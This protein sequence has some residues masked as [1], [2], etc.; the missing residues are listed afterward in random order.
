MREY[1]TND[2]RNIALIGHTGTGKTTLLENALFQAGA[3]P[4]LG[5]V[6]Q[7]N[8]VSDFDDEETRRKVSVQTTLAY[9]EFEGKKINFIDTPGSSDFVGDVRAALRVADGTVILLDAAAGIEIGTEALW[10][11]ADEYHVP[12]LVYVNKMDRE[13]A[14]FY[15][16]LDSIK[17]KFH[18]P[19]VAIQVPI[20]QAGDFRGLIDL[21]NMKAVY[22]DGSGKCVRIEEIPEDMREIANEYREKLRDAAAET[23]DEL[24][25]K[26][27]EGRKL[28]H[29]EIVRGVSRGILDYKIVPVSCGSLEAHVGIQLLMRLIEE[30][31]PSP[32]YRGE[33][34]GVKPGTDEELVRHP[35]PGEPFAAFVFK[36]YTDQYAGRI[37]LL[38]IRSGELLKDQEVVNARTGQKTKIFHIYAVDGKKQ[39]EISRACTGDLVALVK[40]DGLTAG[41]TLCDKDDPFQALPLKVPSPCYFL[42]ITAK[43]RKDEEKLN[44]FLFK[45]AEDDPSFF[46]RY[47]KETRQTVI[48]AMGQQQIDVVLSR[49]ATK[50]RIQV[51]TSVPRVA[52]KETITRAGE[53]HHR[54]KKQSGGHG[55]YGEVY[56]RLA[57]LNDGREFE[58][59]DRIVGGAIPKNF[60]PGVEK[61][62][63]E[64]MGRG[65]LASYPLTGIKVTLYDGTFHDVD[66]SE[67]SFKIAARNALKDAVAKSGPVLLEP[68]M[69]LT[70]FVED[71]LMGDV[72]SDL[73]SRRGRVQGMGG[74]DGQGGIKKINAKVPLSELLRYSADLK[75]LTSGKATFEMGFS[76]YDSFTGKMADMVIADRK[77]QLEEEE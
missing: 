7:G 39:T 77:K 49:I 8:T 42:A 22:P 54:H 25:E 27:L 28:N 5:S 32:L 14:D 70:V 61:G 35:D 1:S 30:S 65:V 34:K 47:N 20:G 69:D 72:L 16:V 4:A 17:E 33:Y 23:D 19:C 56:I 18:K 12:R 40:I 57:P 48:E 46:V 21:I 63:K 9:C 45:A 50:S 71:S 24:I 64:A 15:K 59:E 11:Y 31:L 2:I 26:V 76:H 60:I 6:E 75:S 29:D 62:L 51:E 73:N 52:Y 58:F 37:S 10:R 66:S 3:I 43:E 74:E 36:T 55:Q 67:M 41:D 38:R 53:G 68:V 13:Y 44:S